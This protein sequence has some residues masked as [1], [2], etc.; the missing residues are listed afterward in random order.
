MIVP[1]RNY[2]IHQEGT[3]VPI[4]QEPRLYLCGF[5]SRTGGRFAPG[6]DQR[7]LGQ[8]LN[9]ISAGD[10]TGADDFE[11]DNPGHAERY[12][13]DC[14]RANVGKKR[15]LLRRCFWG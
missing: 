10:P 7:H 5:G 12:E 3:P 9:R 15:E 13:M 1:T 4:I 11:Q 6:H 14:L 2:D 8:C